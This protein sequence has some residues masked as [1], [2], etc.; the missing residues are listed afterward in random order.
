M[1]PRLHLLLTVS[2]LLASV[3]LVTPH[4][5]TDPD[6]L[7]NLAVGRL[8]HQGGPIVG[9]DPFT[10]STPE[11]TWYNPEWLGARLWFELFRLGG[12]GALQGGKLLLLLSA[13][14]LLYTL[15]L[16]RGATPW[17]ALALL[18]LFLP[19]TAWRFTLRNHLH[20]LWLIPLYGLILQRVRAA[21]TALARRGWLFSLLPLAIL[22]ANLHASFVVGWVLLAAA[23]LDAWRAGERSAARGLFWLLCLHPLVALVSPNGVGN[24]TQLLEHLHLL[25]LLR[26]EIQ[27]WAGPAD[28]LTATA[29]IPLLILISVGPLSLVPRYNRATPGAL[30]VLLA[31]VGLAAL[32]QRFIPLAIFLAAPLVAA[33]LAR[34]MARLPARSSRLATGL[35][36]AVALLG[37]FALVRGARA[38]PL[39]P[40]LQRQGTAAPMARFLAA[41]APAGTR[42]FNSY[43]SGP[44][45][46]WLAHP[47][48]VSIYIDPRNHQGPVLL[49]RYLSELLV[50]P[51]ALELEVTGHTITMAQVELYLDRARPLAAHLGRDPR[52]A[53]IYFDGNHA[54]YARRLPLNQRLIREHCLLGYGSGSSNLN[55]AP[56]VGAASTQIRPP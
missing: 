9:S 55:S 13:W 54:L 11:R 15:C 34:I 25:S 24:Y 22:W 39:Q 51:A 44:F 10:F 27:E 18:L 19:G 50:S 36:L 30:L 47:A 43:D 28:T 32:A 45:L 53:L 1:A 2:L 33:N 40:L 37:V 23:L 5:L 3:A 21:P 31:A 6:A 17:L 16:R 56:P 49:R 26:A 41:H 35:T 7:T 38:T 12:E 20:A 46:H 4:V 14:L 42:L 29:R 8:I 52:W 48:G